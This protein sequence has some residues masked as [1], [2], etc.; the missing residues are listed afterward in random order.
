MREM[1]G[2]KGL[3]GANIVSRQARMVGQHLL[4]AVAGGEAAQD[5]PR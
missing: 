5:A 2:R 3:C 1:I 4:D